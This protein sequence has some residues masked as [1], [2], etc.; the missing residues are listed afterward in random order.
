MA[1]WVAG[2]KANHGINYS[3]PGDV[4][5]P[6]GTLLFDWMRLRGL[7][8]NFPLTDKDIEAINNSADALEAAEKIIRQRTPGWLLGWRDIARSTDERTVIASMLPLAGVGNKIPL[9]LIIDLDAPIVACLYSNLTA[10]AYDYTSRQKVGGTTLNYFIYK[11]LPVIP[12]DAYY[13]F[14]DWAGEVLLQDWLLPR[15]LELTYTAW[16]LEP[17]ARECGY[18]GPPFGWDED[19]RFLIRC[20]LDAAYFH[21]YGLERDDVDYIME[22]FPIIKRKDEASYGT[23]RTKEKIL[24]IYDEMAQVSFENA[25]A[26]AADRDAAV[27]YQTRLNPP[28]GPPA[29]WPPPPGQPWPSHIHQPRPE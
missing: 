8:N 28:P 19:R 9:I 20:E 11:Q 25:A 12:P 27:H 18:H 7:E 17:F 13:Q 4:F 16:D 26:L 14:T 1:Q 21:L 3:L 15:V 6:M 23:Y 22:T 5:L 2:Y 10:L 24:E 29:A